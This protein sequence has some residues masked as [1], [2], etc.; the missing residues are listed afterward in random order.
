MGKEL[1]K[2]RSM[3]WAMF[4]LFKISKDAKVRRFTVRKMCSEENKPGQPFASTK[5]I[6]NDSWNHLAISADATEI[7]LPRKVQWKN[8]LPNSMNPH[9]IH[10]RPTKF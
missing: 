6:T 9:D 3:I 7:G 1:L 4:S 5:D 2:K 10:K 8:L